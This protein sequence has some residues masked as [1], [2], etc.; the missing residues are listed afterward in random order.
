VKLKDPIQ[1]APRLEK[2]TFQLKGK[3]FCLVGKGHFIPTDMDFRIVCERQDATSG[4]WVEH[5]K[6]TGSMK[7]AN[8]TD[9]VHGCCTE[10]GHFESSVP[11]GMLK[12]AGGPFRFFWRRRV[13]RAGAPLPVLGA[14]IEEPPALD[15]TEAELGP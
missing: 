6:I 15:V 3:D 7:Y 8:T 14:V 9:V 2:L 4:E 11:V 13:N 5:A 1:V 12:K 10:T